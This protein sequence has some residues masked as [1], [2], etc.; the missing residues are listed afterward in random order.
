VAI[1]STATSGTAA[2]RAAITSGAVIVED[3]ELADGGVVAEA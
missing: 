1:S 2:S 3:V